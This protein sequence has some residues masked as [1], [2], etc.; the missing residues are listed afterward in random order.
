MPEIQ[1]FFQAGDGIR[2]GHVTGVQTFALPISSQPGSASASL[3]SKAT[4]CPRA[5]R[6]PWLIRSE[7]R[8][9]G[10]ECMGLSERGLLKEERCI[11]TKLG[12][13]YR[14]LRKVADR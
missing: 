14:S 11:E 5:W 9:V 12:Q 1:F 7:E 4:Y 8:R 6:M 13:K 2:R 3:F 10:K